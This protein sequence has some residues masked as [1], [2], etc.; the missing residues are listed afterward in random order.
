LLASAPELDR[1]L[2]ADVLTRVFGDECR[3]ARI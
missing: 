3:P 1:P 2:V